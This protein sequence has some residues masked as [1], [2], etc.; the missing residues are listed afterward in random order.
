VDLRDCAARAVETARP[1][2]DA[3]C[4]EMTVSLPDAPVPLSA[5]AARIAQVLANLLNN[6]AKY[7]EPGGRI[8][9]RV[10][11]NGGEAIVRVRDNGIG[12]DPELLPRVFEL[13]TQ[14]ERSLDRSQGGLGIG[15]TLV[16]RLVELH[17]G[18]V[19][20]QSEGVGRGSEF[21]IRLPLAPPGPVV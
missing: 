16:R 8:A 15:L 11:R 18:T 14:A 21:T 9:L 7:T 2:I 20:A 6:A 10:E 5:D 12:I 3:R 17:G 4:H 1:L 13:F 19:E